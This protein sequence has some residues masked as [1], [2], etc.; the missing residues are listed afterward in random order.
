MR[1]QNLAPRVFERI[2]ARLPEAYRHG[3]MPYV[4]LF[5]MLVVSVLLLY[6]AISPYQ[7]ATPMFLSMAVLLL[8]L[9]TLIQFGMP[10]AW[11][12]HIGTSAGALVLLYAVW[13]AG[14]VFSP[15]LAW[16]M[17]LPLT[18]FYVISRKAGTFWLVVVWLLQL[19]MAVCNYYGL[20]PEFEQ[21]LLHAPS[22]WVTFTLVTGVLIIVPMIYERL[23]LKALEKSLR[24]QH[25]LV[26]KRQ[27]LEHT[28]QM[29]EHF[30]ATVSHE[31]RTPMN[32]ILGFNS[33]LL[34]RVK[35]KPEALKVLNHTRQSADHLMT[36]INDILDYS[37]LQA[38]QLVIQPETFELRSV[39][40]HA[41]ELFRPRVK[42][43][44]LDYRIEMDD[45]L[46]QWVHTDRHRL[47]QVLVNLLGNALK[48]T[49]QGSV[50][51]K[52]LWDKPGVVFAVQD[53]GIGIAKERQAQIF[54]RFSQAE[55]DIQ[56]RYGG[57]GLGLAIS[58]KLAQ[59]LGG[60]IGFESEPGR[61]SRFWLRLPLQ[62][63]QP[64]VQ[65]PDLLKTAVQ[66]HQQ[67][68]C[69]LIVDDHPINRLLVK[70]VLQNAWPHSDI[71]EA[72]N[73][74]NALDMLRD[75]PVNLVLMD[76][77][78][79]VMDGIVA[80]RTLRDAF[81][82]PQNALPVL[83]LTANVNP[84]DLERF[85]ASGLSDVMLKPFEPTVLCHKI[86]QLLSTS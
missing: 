2:M 3:K 42:S 29:R 69:F 72:M 25:E 24:Y 45:D 4:F 62:A 70:Q 21:G 28:L 40:E 19:G 43:M 5:V 18:P 46:P 68:W 16:L 73:G 65:K 59:L 37:Q 6:V 14:G 22:S 58:Q 80:T 54:K 53:T 83:G 36:V 51:L 86:D 10:L 76:M 50:V 12:V 78:M 47:M 66:T 81:S 9:L 15:R 60:D 84:M 74:Q 20:L 57:N 35:D 17:I 79:P 32:A 85:K 39:A 31:L 55:G 33:L 8:F 67:P 48:F 1:F 61:G 23:H 71:L 38:G 44:K 75:H 64:P 63:A 34:A 77:V 52:L 30:I 82:A 27:E 11:G 41:F 49:H 26:A 7:N 13:S 56:S